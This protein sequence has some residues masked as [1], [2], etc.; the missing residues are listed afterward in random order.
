MNSYGPCGLVE[1][2][3]KKGHGIFFVGWILLAWSLTGCD[4]SAHS[5]SPVT[6][7]PT[8]ALTRTSTPTPIFD[9]IPKSGLTAWS[10][11]FRPT[12]VVLPYIGSS[13][14]ITV[15]TVMVPSE[16]EG[17]Q[18]NIQH[19]DNISVTSPA[20]GGIYVGTIVLGPTPVPGGTLIGCLLLSGNLSATTGN[21]M[22]FVVTRVGTGD[23][24]LSFG[25]G[26]Q[27]GTQFS[28]RG[29]SIGPGIT[30]TLQTY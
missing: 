4:T 23:A 27:L 30:N 3:L 8:P 9:S 13:Y 26:G 24:L 6:L 18:L 2:Y 28:D 10:T 20:C 12:T 14:F 29:T 7:T 15:E 1:P 25:L 16:A 17:V 22:T 11:S 21:V 19:A 5:T